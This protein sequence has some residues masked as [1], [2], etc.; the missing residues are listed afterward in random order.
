MDLGGVGKSL[1]G[2]SDDLPMGASEAWRVDVIRLGQ[3]WRH[4]HSPPVRFLRHSQAKVL[5]LSLLPTQN[6]QKES[7]TSRNNI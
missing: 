4:G 5:P 7:L 3:T 1:A 2:I 6:K